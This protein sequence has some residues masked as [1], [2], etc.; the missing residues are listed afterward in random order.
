MKFKVTGLHTFKHDVPV[1]VPVDGG[2]EDQVLT[3]VFRVI[4]AAHLAKMNFLT[5]EGQNEFL[6]A[7]IVGFDNLIDEAGE[8]VIV[9]DRVRAQVLGPGFVRQALIA[10]YAEAMTKARV[11]N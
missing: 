3:T 2:H 10:A 1:R 6:A 4:D 9:N 5:I 7:A 11:G 8:E